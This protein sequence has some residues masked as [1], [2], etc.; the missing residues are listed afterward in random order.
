MDLKKTKTDM[1]LVGVTIMAFSLVLAI[2]W[3]VFDARSVDVERVTGPDGRPAKLVSCEKPQYC[4]RKLGEI[5]PRGWEVAISSRSKT[6][7]TSNGTLQPVE[8]SSTSMMIRC[9]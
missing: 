2:V 4:L 7:A 5:C 1:Y 6:R 3:A 8:S 9:K